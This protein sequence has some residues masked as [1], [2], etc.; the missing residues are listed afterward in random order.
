MTVPFPKRF[1]PQCSH[2]SPLFNSSFLLV[3]YIL[4]GL[5][6]IQVLW[7]MSPG[8]KLSHKFILLKYPRVVGSV[9]D[10]LTAVVRA[11]W[12]PP[13]FPPRL[14][15]PTLGHT[16]R[17]PRFFWRAKTVPAFT[18][19]RVSYHNWK[20]ISVAQVQNGCSDTLECNNSLVE[21]YGG[22]RPSQLHPRFSLRHRPRGLLYSP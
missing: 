4:R 14:L 7:S 16:R 8:C 3:H 9:S 20:A 10:F 19:C 12:V 2:L 22:L 15:V 17:R 1:P 18:L 21:T 5:T 11:G 13:V 6:A